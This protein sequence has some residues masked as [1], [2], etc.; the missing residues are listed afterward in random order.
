MYI[1]SVV[2]H[3]LVMSKK[4]PESAVTCSEELNWNGIE[5]MKV[6]K[7]MVINVKDQFQVAPPPPWLKMELKNAA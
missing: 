4:V 6:E 2:I 5:T 1:I 7:E 3:S